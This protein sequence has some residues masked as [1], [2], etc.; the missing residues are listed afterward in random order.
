MQNK[1]KFATEN[2][3]RRGK[4]K[5]T[6]ATE[7]KTRKKINNSNNKNKTNT[8]RVKTKTKIKM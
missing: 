5:K 3:K 7:A 4:L 1:Y 8:Q 6:Q 2:V